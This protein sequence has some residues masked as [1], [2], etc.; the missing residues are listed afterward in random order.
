MSHELLLRNA[1]SALVDI[2]DRL[3]AEDEY[4]IHQ[5]MGEI[6]AII[7]LYDMLPNVYVVTLLPEWS[8]ELTAEIVE[9]IEDTVASIAEDY[10]EE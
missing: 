3:E 4:A 6:D 10:E 1:V 7:K 2:K 8:E 5:M 9:A